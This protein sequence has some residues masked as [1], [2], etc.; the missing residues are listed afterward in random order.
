MVIVCP[1]VYEIFDAIRY[2]PPPP[3]APEKPAFVS[4]PPAP[5]PP[6]VSIVLF[7]E[8]Q[9]LGTVKV[10]APVVVKIF[11]HWSPPGMCVKPA[12]HCCVANPPYNLTP[13]SNRMPPSSRMIRPVAVEPDDGATWTTTR[14][15]IIEP[16]AELPPPSTPT[17][18]IPT[19]GRV[20]PR[21]L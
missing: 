7:D 2:S 6:M 14:T 15:V 9:L 5:P 3:P 17:L 20:H 8:F 16:S 21:G 13:P 18:K 12:P 10:P 19:R 1:G 4:L 11:W